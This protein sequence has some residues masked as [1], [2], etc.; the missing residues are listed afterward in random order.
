MTALAAASVYWYES[1]SSTLDEARRLY[2]AGSTPPFWVIADEQSAGRGRNGRSWQSTP[3]NLF[4]T[5]LTRLEVPPS[6]A[7]QLSFVTALAASD[8]IAS[9][10]PN[11]AHTLRLKWPNDVLLGDAKVAGILLESW[12]PDPN[13]PSLCILIGV[14][15]NLC[16]SPRHPVRATTDLG[17]GNSRESI[18]GAFRSLAGSLD[19]WMEIWDA[20]RGF[21]A[22]RSAW[23]ARARPISTPVTVKL[24]KQMIQGTFQGLDKSGALLLQKDDNSIITISAGDVFFGATPSHQK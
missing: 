10:A 15:I 23:L 20:G 24:N 2:V 9:L 7:A 22:I 12:Q 17:L 11:R 1:V 3:G 4:A 21:D 13:S 6:A 16:D 18:E 5:L 19:R 8:V 14:G